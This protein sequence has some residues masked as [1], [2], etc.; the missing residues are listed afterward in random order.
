MTTATSTETKIEGTGLE[1]FIKAL[2]EAGNLN[3]NQAKTLAYY[4][5]MTW[6]DVPRIRPIID[7]NGE[8]GTG[9]NSIMKQIKDWCRGSVWINARNITP[10]Q[11]RDELADTITAFVEEA[12]KTDGQKESENW[13]QLRY[14]ET[15][16]DK[17]YRKLGV[18]Q[19]GKQIVR[20]ETHDH[21]G[22]TI[23]HT[24]NPF[25]STEMDRRILRITIYK[26]STRGYKV[27]ELPKEE[28]PVEILE[29]ID[30]DKEIEGAQSNSAWDVWLPLMRIADH[31]GDTTFLD[32]ARE[33]IRLKTEEDDLSKV[34]EPKG[35]VLSEIY[36]LY[37]STLEIGRRHIAITDIRAGVRERDCTL[38][39]RQ[40]VKIAKELGFGIVY[41]GN[42][43][44]VRVVSKEELRG[45][46]ERAGVAQHYNESLEATEAIEVA[47]TSTN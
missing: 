11:L 29:E 22:Y 42:K 14:E 16:K 24:Q 13:Y 45:I 19:K 41:P 40:I 23:L 1:P 35:I 46:F 20:E 47:V 4:A 5:L 21:Y 27:T 10:A 12:D 15:G 30:W 8:S 6:S 31:V 18:T 34:Y 33:Q 17:G 44:Y 36:P 37:L 26:D 39:E 43:A 38:I 9:K 7:L 2:I 32:Y 28:I 25:Q 3:I